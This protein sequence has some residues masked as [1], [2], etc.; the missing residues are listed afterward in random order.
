MTEISPSIL[1][2][3]FSRLAEECDTMKRAGADML[4]IDVMDGHFV[5]N[6]SLGAPVI[7]CLRKANDMVF[8]VHLMISDPLRYVDDFAAAGSDILTF[9]LEADSDTA[10]TIAAIKEKGMKAGLSIKPATPAEAVFPFLPQLDLVLIMTV[11]P[12]FGGQKF[13]ADMLPKI[14]KIKAEADRIGKTLYIEV[15]GGIGE[16]NAPLVAKAGANL[17]VAGSSLFLADDR[18]KAVAGLRAAADAAL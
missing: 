15:D 3:D 9:H 1:A 17:L 5:P 12:G 8:D 2:C 11:E 6:I 4:H 7:K 10:A 18:V 13:M 14:E 16:S